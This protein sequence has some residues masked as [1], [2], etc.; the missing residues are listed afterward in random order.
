[1]VELNKD[2]GAVTVDL[3]RHALYT[4]YMLSAGNKQLIWVTGAAVFI[5]AG[6]FRE[7]Q[8]AYSAQAW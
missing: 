8:A 5:Y 1:M 7:N 3:L 4:A 6:K 2:P